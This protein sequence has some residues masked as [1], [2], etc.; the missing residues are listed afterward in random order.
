MVDIELLHNFCFLTKKLLELF[1]VLSLMAVNPVFAESTEI[2]M[3]WLIEGQLEEETVTTQESEIVSNY[4]ELV[5][6][7]TEP[8][9]PIYDKFI[10]NNKYSIGDHKITIDSE[11]GQILNGMLIEQR[12]LREESF[13]HKIRYYDRF[14]DGYIEIA[15]ALLDPI[16]DSKYLIKGQAF[17]YNPNSNLE[18]GP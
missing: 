11:E 14:S 13:K 9:K 10:T 6:E 18:H 15:E 2:K 8:V 16:G 12:D 17:D 7:N 1:F 5:T 4:E 3:D